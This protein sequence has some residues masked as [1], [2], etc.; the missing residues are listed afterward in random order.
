[1]LVVPGAM[2]QAIRTETIAN[3]VADPASAFGASV[4]EVGD[5]T[6]DGTSDLAVGAPEADSYGEADAV[7][8]AFIV[9]GTDGTVIRTLAGT[10][11]TPGGRFG[12]AVASVGDV[13]D[14][15]TP[16]IAIGAPGEAGTGQVYIVDGATGTIVRVIAGSVAGGGFGAALARMPD[17][18]GDGRGELAVGAPGANRVYVV[19]AATGT[20][21]RSVIGPDGGRFGTA[22][23]SAPDASGDATGDGVADLAV[24]AP[25]AGASGRAYLVDGATGALVRT[26]SGVPQPDA[27]FGTAVLVLPDADADGRADMAV[28]APGEDRATAAAAGRV[29]VLSGRTGATIVAHRAP[30]SVE[31]GAL[32]AALAAGRDLDGD[33]VPDVLAGAPG[34][35]RVY[36]LSSATDQR[37]GTLAGP[38]PSGR[39]GAAV[40]ATSSL[41]GDGVADIAVGAPDAGQSGRVYVLSGASGER[42]FTAQNPAESTYTAFGR[43]IAALGDTDGGAIAIGAPGEA[44]GVVHIVRAAGGAILR[45][46]QNPG[47]AYGFGLVLAAIGDADGDGVTDLAAGVPGEGSFGLART[48]RAY[49]FSGATG[50]RLHTFDSPNQEAGAEFGAAVAAAGDLDGD[51]RGDLLIGAPFEDVGDE[52]AGRV[53]AFSGATG[54]RIRT[55]RAAIRRP[56]DYFGYHIASAGDVTGDGLPDLLVGSY[57][58]GRGRVHSLDA[59]DGTTRFDVQL[60]S[61][62]PAPYPGPRPVPLLDR[63]DDGRPDFAVGIPGGYACQFN[64][65]CGAV[66]LFDGAT[67]TIADYLLSP[68]AIPNGNFGASVARLGDTDGDGEAEIAVFASRENPFGTPTGSGVVY[69]FGE[70]TGD[71]VGFLQP[72]RPQEYGGSSG[73]VA[74]AG[75]A[76]GDGLP[77]LVLGLPLSRDGAVVVYAGIGRTVPRDYPLPLWQPV[78]PYSSSHGSSVATMAAGADDGRPDVAVGNPLLHRVTVF[79]GTSGVLRYVVPTPSGANAFGAALAAVRDLNGDGVDDLLAGAPNASWSGAGRAG[80]AFV[81]SGRTGTVLRPLN[82][83][84]PS[85]GSNFGSAVSSMPDVDGDDVPDLLVGA[86]GGGGPGRAFAFSGATGNLLFGLSSPTPESGGLFGGAVGRA[87][88]LDGDGVSDL[89]VGAPNESPGA[90]PG[91]AGRVHLFSGVTGA[92]LRTIV[93]PAEVADGGFGTAVDRL[94]VVSEDGAPDLAVGAPGESGGRVHLFRATTGAVAR[95][96]ASPSGS[97][98][99]SFGATVA[100]AG[101]LDRRGGVDLAV[102]APRDRPGDDAGGAVYVFE[103]ETGELLLTYVSRDRALGGRFG[104][105]VVGAGGSVDDDNY[106]DLFVGAPHE[107]RGGRAY[108]LAASALFPVAADAPPPD[109]PVPAPELRVSPNPSRGAAR[110]G[111]TLPEAADVSVD[112]FDVLGRRVSLLVPGRLPAGVHTFTL[113]ARLAA[114][115]YV[116]RL[117]AGEAIV[118]RRITRL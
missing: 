94:G 67:G 15:G 22:V 114:G 103:G 48:G 32:G 118:T 75:D 18:T 8:R 56:Y 89:A 100:L 24:G 85:A 82:H 111:V 23:A 7:G 71:V 96:L 77:D 37:L 101:N 87:R 12:A 70:V 2:A 21:I 97:T 58:Q 79:D 113:D 117:R 76:D 91:G 38:T 115:V 27:A 88:D 99:A 86:P 65:R 106:E 5:V 110:V 6:G 46:I 25:E 93:S 53:Y 59:A 64:Q 44:A 54:A 34:E 47:T 90:S 81:L 1:M 95:T 69:L 108:V 112:V 62:Y 11:P 26:L 36:A 80:R 41:D 55:Y 52:D 92:W 28:G 45:T 109:A 10:A 30:E 84:A 19:G 116:V 74:T 14:D 40:T 68:E 9:S 63:N 60:P 61:G 50:E 66:L 73:V 78:S 35:A 16:D 83:P 104:T 105:V 42:L 17:L 29:Y 31:D 43:D 13:T 20:L 51:G 57:D 39:F 49:L 102:G 4:A 33:G 107:G 3:P 98:N 72:P